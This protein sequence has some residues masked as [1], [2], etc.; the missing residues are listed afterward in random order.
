MRRSTIAL[1]VLVVLMCAA[2]APAGEGRPRVSVFDT[3]APSAE[4]VKAEALA[5]QE[6]WTKIESGQ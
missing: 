1:C 3:G 4:P 6:G 2:A 5:S